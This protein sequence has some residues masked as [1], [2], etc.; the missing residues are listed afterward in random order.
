MLVQELTGSADTMTLVHNVI[1][2]AGIKTAAIGKG[3]KTSVQLTND[4]LIKFGQFSS[5]PKKKAKRRSLEQDLLEEYSIRWDDDDHAFIIPIVSLTGEMMGWQ[6]K[7]NGWVKNYPEGVIK[8]DTLFGVHHLGVSAS[9]KAVL[10]ESPLDVVRW[11]AV[12]DF[13]RAVASFGSYVS[14]KQI[15]LLSRAVDGLVVAMD[16]DPAGVSSTSR[17]FRVLPN[18]RSGVAY[19]KYPKGVKDVGDMSDD[20]IVAALESSAALPPWKC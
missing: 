9:P 6:C 14:D 10:V 18:F 15:R 20:Q 12:W 19:L 7:G 11:A 8:S 13:P 17:L 16:N 3:V 5:V 4:D 1:I 2:E